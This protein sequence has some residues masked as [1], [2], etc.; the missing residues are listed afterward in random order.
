[1]SIGRVET[2]TVQ[3]G[4]NELL[5][6]S[7]ELK[8][9]LKELVL[10]ERTAKAGAVVTLIEVPVGGGFYALDVERRQ[11]RIGFVNSFLDSYLKSA[12]QSYRP[13]WASGL[14]AKNQETVALLIVARS[15]LNGSCYRPTCSDQSRMYVA[16][17]LLIAF[18]Q[19]S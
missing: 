14:V 18:F 6:K 11:A 12:R 10:I 9:W 17:P 16:Q 3:E 7:S 15:K 1:M 13:D 19:H 2:L 4:D 5:Q 8:F